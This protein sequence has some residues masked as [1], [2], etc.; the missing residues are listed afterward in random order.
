VTFEEF[1]TLLAEARAEVEELHRT[2]PNA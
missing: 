1:D 2:E